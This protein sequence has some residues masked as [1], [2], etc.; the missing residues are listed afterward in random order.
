MQAV[1]VWISVLAECTRFGTEVKVWREAA[2]LNE[3]QE[4]CVK[5][6]VFGASG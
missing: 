6:R 5:M 4:V 1:L 3:R 2:T